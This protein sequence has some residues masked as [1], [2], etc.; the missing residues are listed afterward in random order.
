MHLNSTLRNGFAALLLVCFAKS[1]FS[2][3]ET[4][5]PSFPFWKTNGNINTNTG[6]NFIG[7]VDNFSLAFRTNNI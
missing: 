5:N 6:T 2:Q 3:A 7:T 4:Q 1:A